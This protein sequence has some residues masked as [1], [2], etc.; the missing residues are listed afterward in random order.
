[1]PK[2]TVIDHIHVWVKDR[3]TSAFWYQRIL[4]LMPEARFAT[5]AEKQDGP[6]TLSNSSNTVRIALFEKPDAQ[7]SHAV[8]AFSVAGPDFLAWI[9]KLAGERVQAIDGRF[10]ARDCIRDHKQAWSFYFV[11]PDG[12]PFEITSYDY[13]WLAAKLRN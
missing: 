4:G 11:D 1:M 12:N 9:D 13:S 5:W 7:A 2:L 10:L 8:I 6:L 3:A